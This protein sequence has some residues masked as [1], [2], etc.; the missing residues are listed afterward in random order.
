MDKLRKMQ[1]KAY[2]G[3]KSKVG[4]NLKVI[5]RVNRA[6]TT[7]GETPQDNT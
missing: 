3:V 1:G 5:Y 6:K 2:E 7:R 4:R